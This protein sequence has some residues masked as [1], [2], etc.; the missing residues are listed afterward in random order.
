MVNRLPI[1]I[2]VVIVGTSCKC[3]TLVDAITLDKDERR[4]KRCEC[5]YREI[6]RKC[7]ELLKEVDRDSIPAVFPPSSIDTV[8]YR[9]RDTIL[10]ERDRIKTRI[11]FIRD[12]IYVDVECPG[13]TVYIQPDPCP[14]RIDP[15]KI[16][17]PKKHWYDRLLIWLGGVFMLFIII[18]LIYRAWRAQ[19]NKR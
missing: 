12:S 13:D 2:I 5:D 7:P 8:V 14:P 17:K 9:D 15:N 4:F 3:L 10:I 16:S 11:E 1:Y 19:M 6:G 18:H